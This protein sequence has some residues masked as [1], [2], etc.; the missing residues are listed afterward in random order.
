MWWPLTANNVVSSL[1][2]DLSVWRVCTL[3]TYFS[4]GLVKTKKLLDLC[5]TYTYT[6]DT[7]VLLK[8]KI[9]KSHKH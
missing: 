9:V 3:V 1:P 6:R 2:I 7:H 4:L 5:V 8:Q